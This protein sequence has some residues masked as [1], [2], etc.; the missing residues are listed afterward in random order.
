MSTPPFHAPPLPTYSPLSTLSS[1]SN[2]IN[3]ATVDVPSSCE[4]KSPS[5][6]D[7]SDP[8]SE[9]VCPAN[10]DRCWKDTNSN[11]KRKFKCGKCPLSTSSQTATCHISTVANA[12]TNTSAWNSASNLTSYNESCKNKWYKF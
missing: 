5:S 3:C 2:V 1:S 12:N 6:T 7:R 9:M 8:N 11:E 4:W 10:Q